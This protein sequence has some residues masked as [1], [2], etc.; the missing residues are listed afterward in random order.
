MS[1]VARNM[2]KHIVGEDWLIAACN[3]TF[4]KNSTKDFDGRYLERL[5]NIRDYI[6]KFS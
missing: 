2:L 5:N 1:R 3:G 4:K 6:T